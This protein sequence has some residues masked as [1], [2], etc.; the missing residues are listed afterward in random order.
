[1]S[2]L[3]NLGLLT[4]PVFVF[5]Q[6]G[7]GLLSLSAGGEAL[8]AA[9]GLAPDDRPS[10]SQLEQ[11]IAAEGQL[12]ATS[13]PP[14]D[15]G[16]SMRELRRTC[17]TPGGATIS[18]V[19]MWSKS[20]ETV[21]VV[22]ISTPHPEETSEVDV[23]RQ[24]FADLLDTAGDA[25]L[26]IDAEQNIVLFNRQAETLFGFTSA[27][28]LGR[29]LSLLLPHDMRE[30]HKA[31]VSSFKGERQRSRLMSQRAEIRGL[32]K[33]GSSFP[34]E[35][36]IAKFEFG[37]SVVYTAV[38]RDLSDR[39]KALDYLR[40]SEQNLARA[41]RIAR[42]GSW[43]WNLRADIITGSTETYRIF[44]L[45][46]GEPLDYAAFQRLV[47]PDDR[48]LVTARFRKAF[49]AGES[50]GFGHRIVLGDGA[51]RHVH[52][53][54]EIERGDLGIATGTTGTIQDVTS[55]RQIEIELKHAKEEAEAANR[56][57]SEFLANISHELRTPLNAI[58]GFSEIMSSDILGTLDVD[59][60]REYARDIHSSGEHLLEV[61]ND[62]LDLAR[63]EAGRTIL[64]E[65]AFAPEDMALDCLHMMEERASAAGLRIEIDA[66]RGLPRLNGDERFCKQILIN[67]LS[68]AIKFTPAGGRV[69]IGLS[70]S[71]SNEFCLSVKDSGIGIAADDIPR[72][73]KPFVQIESHLSRRFQGTGLGL[74]LC[75]EFMRLH[76]GTLSIESKLGRGTVVTARFPAPRLMGYDAD[77]AAPGSTRVSRP[78]RV[79]S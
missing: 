78:A 42:I 38:V 65:A 75:N 28:I 55:L 31:H 47:H 41:Q 2:K 34:A 15:S 77:G 79:A 19:R 27:E 50:C 16:S 49:E 76:D 20:A 32:R 63:I 66:D 11:R 13:L 71:P 44:G 22:E 43:H 25:I 51:V 67:L 24:R 68:N 14:S 56:A 58:L 8:L 10:L 9:L 23:L 74:S 4:P 72:L 6:I 61:V 57:K 12:I 29:P 40:W 3:S 64:H 39:N 59:R 36:S 17:L 54:M 35:A 33:D 45:P 1:M 53:E 60:Y 30:Q 7:G 48:L 70:V 69:C 46:E 62:V 37:G 5:D 73:M 52:L 18:M 21:L 26:S